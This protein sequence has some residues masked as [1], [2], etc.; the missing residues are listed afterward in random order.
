MTVEQAITRCAE[1]I[2]KVLHEQ[3]EVNVL[4]LSDHLGEKSVITYQALG[5]LAREARIHYE[6][7]GNQVYVSAPKPSAQA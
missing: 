2:L 5:W 6:V 1:R 4:L 3:G 7:R